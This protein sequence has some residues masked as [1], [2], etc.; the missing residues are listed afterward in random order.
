MAVQELR[1]PARL[2][3]GP[4]V[5]QHAAGLHHLL[6][7]MTADD[8]APGLAP[9][10]ADAAAAESIAHALVTMGRQEQGVVLTGAQALPGQSLRG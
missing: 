10:F 8:P 3:L 4:F 1:P 7:R 6:V 2:S 5:D 9:T